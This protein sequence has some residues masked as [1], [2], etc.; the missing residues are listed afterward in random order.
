[1]RACRRDAG[2]APAVA[3]RGSA[4]TTSATAARAM[5][6]AIDGKFGFRR[7]LAKQEAADSRPTLK[8]DTPPFP[9]TRLGVNTGAGRASPEASEPARGNTAATR[10]L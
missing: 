6:L 5:V 10:S 4:T 7:T 8:H 1:M 2:V 3:L 9:T